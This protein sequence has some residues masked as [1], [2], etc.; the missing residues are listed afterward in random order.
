NPWTWPLL[1]LLSLLIL[2]L[3]GTIIALLIPGD[4]GDPV[5]P[6][7]TE[8]ETS[9]PPTTEPP[10][11]ETI[12]IN[13]AEFLGRSWEFTAG[14]LTGRGL[15][16]QKVLGEAASSPDEVDTV[17]DVSP[18]SVKLGDVVYVTVIAP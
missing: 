9:A 13:K 2:V 4:D 17:V 6:P 7:P 16:P 1:G 14:V 5:P 11:E 3:I 15:Q 18:S 12:N 8:T 10:V